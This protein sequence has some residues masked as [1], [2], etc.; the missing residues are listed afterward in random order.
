VTEHSESKKR[1][2]EGDNE[3]DGRGGEK[4]SVGIKWPVVITCSEEEVV[5]KKSV[6]N[7]NPQCS[8]FI[9]HWCQKWMGNESDMA[10]DYE[11]VGMHTEWHEDYPRR[12][13]DQ[14]GND[15]DCDK[16]WPGKRATVSVGQEEMR[17]A[18][19]ASQEERMVTVSAGQEEMRATVSVIKSAQTSFEETIVDRQSKLLESLY[20]ECV[21]KIQGTRLNIYMPKSVGSS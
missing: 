16:Y 20:E 3:G 15:V 5:S 8:N 1:S 13:G 21:I 19:S 10:A 4:E 18:L 6:S 9:S 7:Q 2:Q 11:P 12:D 17:A 14:P